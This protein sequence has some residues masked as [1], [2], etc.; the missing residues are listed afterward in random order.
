MRKEKKQ[1]EEKT[2][3]RYLDLTQ[4]CQFLGLSRTT[5][6]RYMRSGHIPYTMVGRQRKFFVND[7]EDFVRKDY[8]H[9]SHDPSNRL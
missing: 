5:F 9:L 8:L 4:A 2:P 7:L 6:Y 3:L 1:V